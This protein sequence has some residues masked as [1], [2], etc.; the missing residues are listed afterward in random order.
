MNV[1]R[2]INTNFNSNTISQLLID[3]IIKDIIITKP[4]SRSLSIQNKVN[5][6][7][8]AVFGLEPLDFSFQH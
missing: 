3:K 4:Q 5:L 7:K 6:V 8:W 2:L 1:S